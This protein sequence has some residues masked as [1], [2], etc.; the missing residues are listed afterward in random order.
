M[1]VMKGF[2]N[3]LG[4]LVIK[5]QLDFFIALKVRKKCQKNHTARMDRNTP[6][7]H[8]ISNAVFFGTR[9]SEILFLHMGCLPLVG[10]IKL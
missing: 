5:S 1:Q 3:G 4:C 10:S 7:Q 6:Q 9:G 2:L 8:K